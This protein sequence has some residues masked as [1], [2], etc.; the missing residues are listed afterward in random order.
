MQNRIKDKRKFQTT[1]SNYSVESWLAFMETSRLN[2][3][4]YYQR[5]YVWETQQQQEFLNN[6]VSGF[7]LGGI[8]VVKT[9]HPE[10][11]RNVYEIVDGKQRLTTLIKF[12]TDEIS[13]VIDGVA[14]LYSGLNQAEQNSFLTVPLPMITLENAT[15]KEKIEYFYFINFSGVPQSNEHKLKII[16]LIKSQ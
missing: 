3:F 2:L 12:F 4:A 6:I 7:P 13:L 11:F 8:S 14:C 16:D 5:D 10:T 9:K 1:V 15:E